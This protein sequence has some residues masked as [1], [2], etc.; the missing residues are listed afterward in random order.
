[1]KNP[2]HKRLPRELREEVGKYLVIFLLLTATIGFVSGF[3]VADGS[4][5]TAYRESFGKY[6]IEDGNFRL[7]RKA[8]QLQR[9]A[10]EEMGVDLYE[11]FYIEEELT[12]GSTLR[13]FQN[14]EAVN[15]VCLMEG[16]FPEQADEI[17]I[18]RMFADNNGLEPG[19]MIESA[20]RSW[21]VTGLVALSD[22]SCLYSSNKDSMFDSVKF[23]VSVV[24]PEAFE[25]FEKDE[26]F[27][28]Y[29]WK[30]KQAPADEAE[31]RDA[32]EEL[33][34]EL[35]GEVAL[36]DFV[37]CYQNQAIQFAGN[38]MGSDRSMMIALLY[39]IIVIMAFVFGIIISN[40]ISKEANVIGTLRA[41]GYTQRELIFH[42][43]TIPMLVTAVGAILG[44]V[45]GYTIFKEVCVGMYYGSYS[46]PTYVTI[47][48]AEAFL[49]TTVVPVLLMLATNY[50]TLRRKLKLSPLK[51][52]RRDLNPR[53]QRRAFPLSP[54]LP[55]FGRFRL[56]VIFQNLSNYC[57][58]LVGSLFA[59]LLV[60]CGMIF[61]SILAHYQ[62]EVGQNML[63]EYQ[64]ML[65]I[66]YSAMDEEH[67][68]ESLLSMMLFQHEAQTENEDAEK[69]SVYALN[70][71]EGIYKSEEVLLY[72]VEPDSRYIS[73][74]TEG[75]QVSVSSAYAEK[76]GVQPG[77]MIV[78]KEAY[79]ETE[80]AFQ[81]G[82][83]YDYL[84]AIAVFMDREALNRTFELGDDYFA[85]YFSDTEITDIDEAYI[86]SVIDLE[87]L[88]KISRQLN[89]SMG[90]MMELVQGF[91]V[92]IF[93]VLVYL[94]SKII[95]ERNAHS[96]SM[97]KIL[98]Y[99]NGEISRLYIV[100]TS[101]M[102]VLFLLLS[103]PIES[104]IMEFLF[105]MIMMSSIP[106]WI[107]FYM[108]PMI[109]VRMFAMGLGTYLVVALLELR[110]IR[111]VPMDAALKH[112]E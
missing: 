46:L 68:L 57:I 56:R 70:T 99:T 112:V 28:S 48:S 36:E 54:V 51:F 90:G 12:G 93:M 98:G 52:L 42:Y 88:T 110:K 13:I 39:I 87:D 18:D 73:L 43:M 7:K 31:E 100:S 78:L 109:Y 45:L 85:G 111:K 10:I 108:D 41:S 44:N 27:W 64:Y 102:V 80:Y 95:I 77:D 89:V 97:T 61:P 69:F 15:R 22:Y 50:G 5:I 62:A 6:N 49:L 75:T 58:L 47:W 101:M 107:S 79:E 60:M 63:S 40:T 92:L 59:N 26:L 32:A 37:P 104:W 35:T 21:K 53:K 11:N 8:N 30:Y 20:A 9:A 4:M 91:A 3:L 33:L 74:E 106:G 17:A 25:E 81:V 23:G 34:K 76:Y 82:G 71:L 66:P 83:I 94:L 86:A 29:S 38:D 65:Q 24:T 67:K 72:G 2:L 14:R 105:Q 103:L 16:E 96:I 19:D 55:F 1:M 84:G